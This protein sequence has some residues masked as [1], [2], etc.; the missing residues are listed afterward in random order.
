MEDLQNNNVKISIIIPVYNVEKYLTE[1]LDSIYNQTFL[2]FEIIIVNDG[3]TDKS[4]EIILKYCKEHNNI[5]YLKQSNLGVSEAR[6]LAI[7]K[8]KGKYTLFLDSDDY[9]ENSMLEKLYNAIESNNADIAICGFKRIYEN[10]N[11]EETVL[12]NV[13]KNKIYNNSEIV[14]KMLNTEIRGFLWN[15]LFL[16]ENVIKYNMHFEKGRY[17]QDWAPVFKQ[18]INAEKIV[19]VNEPLYYYRQREN[20]NLHTIDLKRID[21]FNFAAKLICSYIEKSKIN[22]NERSYYNFIA[23]IQCAEIKDCKKLN[24]KL[25]KNFYIK[26]MICDKSI[27]DILFNINASLKNKIKLILYNTKIIH[28]FYN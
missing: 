10:K 9:I 4:E 17:I 6:N 3:S 1:M 15:K 21:D 13:D 23:Q 27:K 20:S 7:K 16:T 12:F 25:N 8:I 22:I 11:K 26:Y 18:V 19:F 14:D 24:G 28:L 2:Q 5:V